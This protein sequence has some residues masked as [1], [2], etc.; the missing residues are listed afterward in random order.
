MVQISKDRNYAHI[1]VSSS[2]SFAMKLL[3]SCVDANYIKSICLDD[4]DEDEINEFLA[5]YKQDKPIKKESLE[6][7]GGHIGHLKDL[8]INGSS[9]IVQLKTNENI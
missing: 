1:I 4:L 2:D 9:Y 6:M 8:V 5:E 3:Q 7:V